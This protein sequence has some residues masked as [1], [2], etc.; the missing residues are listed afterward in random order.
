MSVIVKK[1]QSINLSKAIASLTTFRVGLSWDESAD[2]DAVALVVDENGKIYPPSENNMAYYGNCT[3]NKF[4]NAENPVPG[5]SHSGD[6]RDGAAEGDD[7]TIVI[8]TTKISKDRVI[9][10]VTSYAEGS[11]VPF[12]A[13]VNPVA[14]LYDQNGAVLL[15]VKLD[16]N[17]AFSTAVVFAEIKKV[18]GEWIFTNV[19]EPAGNS[20]NGLTD[21]LAKFGG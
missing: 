20:V 3:A 18:D 13:A 1:N 21:L 9:I 15:E 4:N 11:A 7:E 10:A 5:L 12:A 17:A 8:D 6:A 14:K 16:E 2:L 19:T